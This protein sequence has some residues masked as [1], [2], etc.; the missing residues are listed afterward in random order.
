MY[1]FVLPDLGEGIAEAELVEWLVE[2]G[3]SVQEDQII[4]KVMTDKAVVEIPSPKTGRIHRL[5]VGEGDITP[6]GDVLIEIDDDSDVTTGE[7]QE[8]AEV[9]D[10]EASP[11]EAAEEKEAPPEPETAAPPPTG[12]Q[13]E[14][15]HPPHMPPC[16]QAHLPTPSRGREKRADAVPAVRELAKQLNIDIE[17]V[18]GTG[19]DGRVMRRDVEAFQKAA[20]RSVAPSTHP[21]VS[22]SAQEDEPDWERQ[23]LRGVRRSIAERVM[24]SKT[25]IPHYTYVEEVDLTS[26]ESVRR[27][28]PTDSAPSPLA[29]IA[30]AALTV[31]PDYPQLNAC[32]DEQTGEIIFKTAIHLGI[33]VTTEEG[34]MV[35]VVCNAGKLDVANLAIKVR[36]LSE[37]A[38]KK[39]L[40]L[41][42]L[43]GSTFT[44]TSLGKLGGVMATPIIN[45]PASAI[46]GVHAIRT[47]P[48]YVD[49]SVQPREIMNLSLSLDHR[50]VD[51]FE[52]AQFIQK[53][54][55]ILQRADFEEFQKGN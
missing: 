39:K 12:A 48:R 27:N 14:P 36:E 5:M 20:K 3:K 18:P 23:S 21:S 2:E 54:R 30:R 38:R 24:R 4:A 44:I 33:A 43:K 34:L 26:L 42:E 10:A 37:R 11:K 13:G 1:Q 28:L 8:M 15:Q 16:P 17:Q 7:T 40:N 6:V 53:V 55:E 45:Y 50:I 52:G 19:P 46:M 32:V 41:S 49:G 25:L 51:G 35:P 29:F 22:E 47:L 9:V 31:L